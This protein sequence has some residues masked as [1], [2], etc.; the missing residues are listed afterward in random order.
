MRLRSTTFLIAA[1]ALAGLNFRFR[2]FLYVL[3]QR[4]T[5]IVGLLKLSL[6]VAPN[7]TFVASGIYQFAFA[8]CFFIWHQTLLVR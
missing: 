3:S 1:I 2:L 5:L 7:V 4:A 8:V 6:S